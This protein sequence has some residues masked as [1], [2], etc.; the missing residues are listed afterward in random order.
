VPSYVP[1]VRASPSFGVSDWVGSSPA[2]VA[3]TRERAGPG[4][5]GAVACLSSWGVK[6]SDRLTNLPR[7]KWVGLPVRTNVTVSPG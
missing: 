1:T 5:S 4:L 3:A 6:V 7:H 2:P